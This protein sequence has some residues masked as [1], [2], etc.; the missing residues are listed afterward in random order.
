MV[1]II[2]VVILI[3]ICALAVWIKQISYKVDSIAES[4]SEPDFICSFSE[5]MDRVDLPI[6]AMN[7][8]DKELKFILDSG[9]NGCH[10]SKGVLEKLNIESGLF[11]ST[12]DIMATGNGLAAASN[13]KCNIKLRLKKYV[14][15]VPFF[16]DDFDAVFDH[17]KNTDGVE[18][19]GILGN[20]FLTANRWV[21]DFA[22]NTAYMKSKLK[23]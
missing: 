8:E 13:K 21:L 6:I 2:I 16:I 22:S 10:I 9:S 18:L 4:T 14:F 15:S 19:H 7:Y 1:Y 17:I 5:Y 11:E 3:I 12:S 20:N 23:K